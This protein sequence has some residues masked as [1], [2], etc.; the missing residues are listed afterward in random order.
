MKNLISLQDNN[1]KIPDRI[2]ENLR[3][4]YFKFSEVSKLATGLIVLSSL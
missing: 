2:H 1:L 4:K 3:E